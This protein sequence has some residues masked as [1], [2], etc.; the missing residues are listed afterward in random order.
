MTGLCT[1]DYVLQC[2]GWR[3]GPPAGQ[4]LLCSLQTSQPKLNPRLTPWFKEIKPEF[5]ILFGAK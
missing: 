3:A 5:R 1:A 4:N 2:T